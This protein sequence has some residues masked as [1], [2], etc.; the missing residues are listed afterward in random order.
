[1][2]V[3]FTTTTLETVIPELLPVEIVVP[4]D[5]KLVPVSVTFT[6]LPRIPDD[7]E[8]DASVGAGDA[9]TA[10]PPVF[11]AP[12]GDTAKLRVPTVAFWVMTRLAVMVVAFTTWKVP[13]AIDTPFPSPV[14]PVAPAKYWP[15]SV[16][17]TVVP[18]VP[19]LG[20]MD[21]IVGPMTVKVA[22][23]FG[24]VG[25]PAVTIT[26]LATGFALAAITKLAWMV[27]SFTTVRPV[28][29]MPVPAETEVA[30]VK[31]LPVRVTATVV[32]SPPDAGE[33]DVSTGARRL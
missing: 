33:T 7:G 16:T 14:M 10:K 22:E 17:G 8:M 11:V 23:G 32:P 26:I 3:E 9:T 2:V 19:V 24:L 5:A 25:D 31:P 29:V 28:T 12:F 6:G 21:V 20:E 27:V 30:V 15:V 13:E 4:V 1:M 18:W